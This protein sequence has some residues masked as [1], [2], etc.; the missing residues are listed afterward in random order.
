MSATLGRLLNSGTLPGPLDVEVLLQPPQVGVSWGRQ[1]Y[2]LQLWIYYR[3][4]E[5]EVQV[6]DIGAVE[7][8]RAD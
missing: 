7:P 3:F 8:S 6:L 1:V 2:G 5:A 4:D